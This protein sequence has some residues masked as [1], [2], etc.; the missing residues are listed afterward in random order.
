[1][2]N[3]LYHRLKSLSDGLVNET[4]GSLEWRV[5]YASRMLLVLAKQIEREGE[6]D[7]S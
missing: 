1:M 4:R 3:K 6:R 5:N 2:D 7:G